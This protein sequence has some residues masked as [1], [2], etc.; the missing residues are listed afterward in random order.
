MKTFIN[1]MQKLNCRGNTDKSKFSVFWSPL[2]LVF[3]MDS[4]YGSHYQ[5]HAAADE[6]ITI[7]VSYEPNLMSTFQLVEK[8]LL[9][10]NSVGK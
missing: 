6:E 9:V 7:N 4:G 3:Q 8:E 2:A 1:D 5:Q 10:E